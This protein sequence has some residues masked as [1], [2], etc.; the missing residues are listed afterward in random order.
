MIKEMYYSDEI[1]SC[2]FDNYND[3]LE[4]TNDEKVKYSK[5]RAKCN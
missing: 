1:L 5:L 2:H 4:K 3:P